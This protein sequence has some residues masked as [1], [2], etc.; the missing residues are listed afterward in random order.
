MFY[1]GIDPMTMKPV[2][3]PKDPQEKAMQRA[4]LQY[5]KPENRHLVM[6]ALIKA[7][8]SD[9]IGN[10]PDCLVPHDK[11]SFEQ[12]RIHQ[13]YVKSD[14]KNVKRD[15]KNAGKKP[16]RYAKGTKKQKPKAKRGR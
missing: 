4:L 5:F 15:V 6:K 16:S 1:T 9:L 12:S 11:K 14:S 3:V 2:Y 8:R 10:G 7:G 13:K